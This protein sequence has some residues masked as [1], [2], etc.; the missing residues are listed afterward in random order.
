MASWDDLKYKLW[1][2]LA[3]TR[4]PGNALSFAIRRTLRWS[5]GTPRLWQES[6]DGLFAYLPPAAA[7]SAEAREAS[8]RERHGLDPLKALSTASLYRKNLYLIECLERAAEGLAS[9]GDPGRPLKALDVGSQDWHYVFGLERWLR[10]LQLG[11]GLPLLTGLELDGYGIYP[12]F[13]SRKDYAEA[14]AAQAGNPQVRYLVGDFL[15]HEGRDYDLVT[16]FYPFVTRYAI[17][18]WGLPLHFFLPGKM[19]A[20]AAEA[21]RP[22]GWL[23]VFN[24]TE[25]EHGV[26]LGLG[27]A[28]GRFELLKSGPVVSDL[29]DFH[30]EIEGRSFS[31]WRRLPD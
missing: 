27:R 13:H 25:E 10:H 29:V 6:K 4:I 2:L 9:P 17:L 21:V 20:K 28:S 18:L 5:R 12:D 31:I 23:L 16:I 19:V 11:A 14:Y 30:A 8:L 22:G 3:F 24:H 1:H 7:A 26:F 15:R